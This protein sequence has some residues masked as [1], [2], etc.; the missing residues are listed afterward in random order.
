MYPNNNCEDCSKC[1]NS[2]TPLPIPDLSEICNDYN[3]GCVLYTGPNISCL[4]I[5]TGMSFLEIL[6]IFNNSLTICDCCEKIPQDCVVS[7]WGP[8]SECQ[9][10]Y[11]AELL[12]CGQQT[13]TRDVI[14]PA[15]NGGTPCGVLIE[16]RDCT[17]EDVC[18]TFGSDTCDSAPDAVQLLLQP[19]GLY[20]GKPYY[21]MLVC[22]DDVVYTFIWYNSTTGLWNI[23]NELGLGATQTLDNDN[24][25]LPLSNNVNYTWST[26]DLISSQITSC[27]IANICF[28]IQILEDDVLLTYF[29]NEAPISLSSNGFPRYGFTITTPSTDEYT[30]VIAY[31]DLTEVWEFSSSLND[32][33]G[34]IMSTLFT[35]PTSFYPIG[36]TLQWTDELEANPV[37]IMSSYGACVQPPDVDCVWTC[38][39]WSDCNAGCTQTRTCTI[40]TPASGNGT[41]E[42]SPA[43]QQSCCDPSCGQPINL[44]ASIIGLNV[45]IIFPAVPGASGYTLSYT[46]DGLSY[47]SIISAAPTF[48]FPWTCG[49]T[50]SGWVITNCATL[51]SV[52]T[53]FSITIPACPEPEFCDGSP[54]TFI[55]GNLN[56]PQQVLLK[57]N[58]IAAIDGT[59]PVLSGL[60]PQLNN[61][62][63]MTNELSQ[64]GIFLGGQPGIAMTDGFGTYTTGGVLKLKCN[65]TSSLFFGEID[66]TFIGIS[67]GQGFAVSPGSTNICMIHAI[68]YQAA[69]SGMPNRIY[70]GGRFDRYKGITCSS[71]LVCLNADTGDIL[72]NTTFKLGAAGIRYSGSGVPCILD[73]QVD[74]TNPAKPL[75]VVAGAF[76]S[77]TSNTN[78]STAAHNIIRL[79]MDGSVDATFTIDGTSFST[80]QSLRDTSTL[81]IGALS[82]VKTVYIDAAG[83]IYAGGAFYTYKTVPSYNIVKIKS[84]GS[85]ANT[86]E[87][88]AGTGFLKPNIGL[89]INSGWTKAYLGRTL[90]YGPPTQWG[91]SVEK[92]IPHVNGILITGNFAYYNSSD[93]TTN[94]ANGL[95]KINT[96]GTRDVSFTIDTTTVLGNSPDFTIGRCGYDI[97]V[98]DDNKVLFAGYLTSYLGSSPSGSR[99]YYI[100]NANGTVNTS[101]TLST[102]GSNILFIK[103]IASY[104]L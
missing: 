14:T 63:F 81:F 6:T 53:P 21:E 97:T 16:T 42:P 58:N 30:C 17:V 2:V 43:L 23:S 3:A 103:T 35:N 7:D 70:V 75:L 104:F 47:T 12:V 52:Q 33:P 55:S 29:V 32:D 69:G 19:A 28:K 71:N 100:L 18:F 51:N 91:V 68:K 66:R 62:Q 96:D 25:Y 22:E 95:I 67:S 84:D 26:G 8:W 60:T 89:G 1:E 102:S 44:N 85:I 10:Y 13:R 74:N 77:H 65:P 90:M 46:S 24:N 72:P 73:I 59:K 101:Y 5:T 40:T 83:D 99:G 27:P 76:N 37:M 9:C 80:Y 61:T 38:T 57:I 34:V 4:N 31:N 20:N 11:E 92:I 82:F 64:N 94:R 78:I 45:A 36:T 86:S 54:T 88:D 93:D 98:L 79:N 87:F 48:S 49:L 41:C 15:L 39:E 56:S 50:Y